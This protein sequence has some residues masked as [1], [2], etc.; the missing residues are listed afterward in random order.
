MN[1]DLVEHDNNLIDVMM[2]LEEDDTDSVGYL[3]ELDD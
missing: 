1:A 3:T 2:G